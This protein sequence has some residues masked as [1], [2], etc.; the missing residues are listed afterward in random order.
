MMRIFMLGDLFLL[1]PKSIHYTY[2][3]WYTYKKK[4]KKTEQN[5]TETE[6]PRATRKN[7]IFQNTK[8]P[9]KMIKIYK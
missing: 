5:R 2:T 1:L 7:N 3:I 9:T 4:Q 6:N 8:R